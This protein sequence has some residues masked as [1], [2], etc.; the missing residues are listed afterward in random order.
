MRQIYLDY[1]ATTP[2]APSVYEAM[3]PFLTRYCGNPSSHH[4]QGL[5]CNQAIEDARELVATMLGAQPDELYFTGGGTESNNLAIL[6]VSQAEDSFRGHIVI[7]A[8]EHPA[9]TEPAK[10]LERMGCSVSVVPTNQNGVV[11][12]QAVAEVL[13]DDTVLVSIMHAN[14]EIGTIQPIQ[15][16]SNVCRQRGVLVHT[17]AAQSV[18]KIRTQVDELG[19]DLLSIAGHKVYAPKGIGALYVRRGTPL[20]PVLHG[21][22]HEKGLRPGTE[23]VA[24]IVG[25]G[26]AANLAHLGL[27]E[28]Q[29]RL[30][31]LRERLFE[32]LQRRIENL[33]YN[34]PVTQ[35]LPNTLSVNFPGVVGQE[36]LDRV[37]D[38]CASTGSACH[39]GTTA[40][41][42]T[43]AAIGLDPEAARGTIRLTLGWTSSEEEVDKAVGLLLQNWETLV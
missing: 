15:E 40:M 13:R 18:G 28:N 16:I 7:S 35:R 42:A 32:G 26:Q 25:L 12:P 27:E 37:P 19:V 17:D 5:I 11:D 9:T 38:I 10:Y 22:G 1:N 21:A 39:S 34:G 29:Q 30:T 23:N 6:G 14:N 4:S 2:V 31:S 43:L 41:S 3:I 20:Q 8:V 24:Y 33:T 36:L